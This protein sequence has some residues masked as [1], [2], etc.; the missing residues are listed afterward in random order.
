[1]SKISALFNL[2]PEF[3]NKDTDAMNPRLSYS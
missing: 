2:F 1:M 3:A